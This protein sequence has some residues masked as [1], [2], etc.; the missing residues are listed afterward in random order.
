MRRC[1]IWYRQPVFSG[2]SSSSVNWKSGY[3]LTSPLVTPSRSSQTGL[4]LSIP[5]LY[6]MVRD[7]SSHRSRSCLPAHLTKAETCNL[8]LLR[9]SVP[10]VKILRRTQ[11][12]AS[13]AAIWRPW[14]KTHLQNLLLPMFRAPCWGLRTRSKIYAYKLPCY[15]PH[16]AATRRSTK[17]H[18]KPSM[19]RISSHTPRH[20]GPKSQGLAVPLIVKLL[21]YMHKQLAILNC[22]VEPRV[23]GICQVPL[24]PSVTCLYV[25]FGKP[26]RIK[27]FVPS[28]FMSPVRTYLDQA[29]TRVP[30]LYA[31]YL[32]A[33][34]L[35]VPM[36]PTATQ[37]SGFESQPS[38]LQSML[39]HS[40]SACPMPATPY[41]ST[42]TR[43]SLMRPHL[44]LFSD[45]GYSCACQA[46]S[47]QRSATHR[48]ACSI[49]KP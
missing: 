42:C 12:P 47:C 24:R 22:E 31:K 33:T 36:R 29:D 19:V 37:C 10:T 39:Q 7:Y 27:S 30:D 21:R 41:P 14:I 45:T 15:F 8:L 44:L 43:W 25:S 20:L 34:T 4:M 13:F 46:R 2:H 23:G 40:C 6:L 1:Q 9:T 11:C 49:L 26:E 48:P 18:L 32:F 38:C 17:R 5:A 16:Y 28:F 3:T 35:Q